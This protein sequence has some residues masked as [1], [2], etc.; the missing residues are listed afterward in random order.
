[1]R[2]TTKSTEFL[3]ELYLKVLLKL[4]DFFTNILSRLMIDIFNNKYVM[5]FLNNIQ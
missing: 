4:N 1:L 3:I 2:K 5:I